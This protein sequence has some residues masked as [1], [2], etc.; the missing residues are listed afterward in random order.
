VY[1]EEVPSGVR[2]ITGV[3][4]SVTAFLGRAARGPVNEPTT[5]TSFADYERRF[6]G[7]WEESMLGYAVRDFFL[8]GGSQAIIVRLTNGAATAAITLETDAS[9]SKELV[10]EAANPGAWGENLYVTVD[11]STE[12]PTAPVSS[13]PESTDSTLFNLTVEERKDGEVQQVE[14]F[15]N[16]SL[17]ESYASYLPRILEESSSLRGCRSRAMGPGRL[18]RAVPG[19]RP[20][21]GSRQ[22]VARTGTTSRPTTMPATGARAGKPASMPWRRPTF[23]ICSAFPHRHATV[24]RTPRCIRPR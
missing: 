6:G 3:A 19:R 4:T 13:P 15:L 22:K 18:P 21:G 7:L 17:E 9:P 8:N 11:H 1:V 5:I 23:S 14:Q 12:D 2:T 16:V 24:T 20:T 10:L